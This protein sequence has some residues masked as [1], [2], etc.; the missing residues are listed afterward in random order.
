M[1]NENSVVS[2]R[3]CFLRYEDK[4]KP[5]VVKLGNNVEFSFT[6]LCSDSGP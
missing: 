4:K 6:I 3:A 5:L 1:L 2:F